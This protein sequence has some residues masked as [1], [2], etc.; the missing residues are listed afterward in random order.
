VTDLIGLFR[1]VSE[2][3]LAIIQHSV[4]YR[5]FDSVL[6]SYATVRFWSHQQG[7]W[8]LIGNYTSIL[9]QLIYDCQMV[10]LAQVLAETG[11]NQDADIGAMIV[12]IRDQWLL[13]D[14]EGPVVELLENRLLG[15]RIGQTEVRPAQL[16][17]HA[18]GETLVWSDVI[19]HLSG[20]HRIIF[21]GIAEARRIFDQELC[22]SGQSS[23]ASDILSLELG[24]LVDNWDA[25]APGQSFLTDSRNASYFDPLKEWLV[26]RAGKTQA[27]FQTFWSQTTAGTWEVRADAVQQYEDAEQRF[28]RALMIPFSLGPVNRGVVPSLLHFGGGIQP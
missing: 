5:K 26:S 19:F 7:A 16:R 27:L 23:P 21:E 2:F 20:L 22:L 14:T 10:V 18:D 9:S 4:R 11:D 12:E 25:T 17:W 3:S 24:L 13:N 8:M 15:F 6:V 1:A 28:L